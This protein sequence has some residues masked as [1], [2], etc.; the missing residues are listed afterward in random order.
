M[1][2]EPGTRPQ[3]GKSALR[4]TVAAVRAAGFSNTSANCYVLAEDAP[5]GRDDEIVLIRLPL[6]QQHDFVPDGVWTLT[7]AQPMAFAVGASEEERLA[8]LMA[9]N[10]TRTRRA[11]CR[12]HP[13]ERIQPTLFAGLDCRDGT[14]QPWHVIRRNV[15]A[16]YVCFDCFGWWPEPH[17]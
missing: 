2:M 10:G 4:E 15:P 12:E 1:V 13:A 8:Q 11:A 14:R 17:L 7:Q 16:G 5:V 9:S 3:H 6:R